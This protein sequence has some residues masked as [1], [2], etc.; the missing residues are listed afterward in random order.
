M[1]TKGHHPSSY[2]LDRIG[3]GEVGSAYWNLRSAE[4]VEQAVRLGEARLA[5]NGALVVDTD[6]RTGRSPN[7][8]FVY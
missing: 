6:K 5:A 3:L 1:E 2:G 8:K 4:L 7:D